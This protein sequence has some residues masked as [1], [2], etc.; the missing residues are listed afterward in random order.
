[1]WSGG[2]IFACLRAS[3][4]LSALS[5]P[6]SLPLPLK[7]EGS[8]IVILGFARFALLVHRRLTL[9]QQRLFGA[10]PVSLVSFPYSA[11]KI[12]YGAYTGFSLFRSFLLNLSTTRKGWSVISTCSSESP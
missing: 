4:F 8:D 10:L 12:A 7:G 6:F 3:F 11:L 9:A 2:E 1:M 5:W